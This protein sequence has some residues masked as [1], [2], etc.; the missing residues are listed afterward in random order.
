VTR[1]RMTTAS[2]MSPYRSKRCCR[3]SDGFVS[4]NRD[5]YGRGPLAAG[6]P[7]AEDEAGAAI[8]TTS[9]AKPQKQKELLGGHNLAISRKELL[10]SHFT[11]LRRGTPPNAL[12]AWLFMAAKRGS[13]LPYKTFTVIEVA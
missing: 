4:L 2:R 6:E 10:G 3:P 7:D 9:L 1:S 12:C 13:P 5:R 8:T 11:L